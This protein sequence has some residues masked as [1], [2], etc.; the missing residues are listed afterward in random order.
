MRKWTPR[1]RIV[2][3][4]NVLIAALITRGSPPDQLYRA[5]IRGDFELITSTAQI[6]EMASVLQRPRLRKYINAR[7]AR[8]VVENIDTR[9]IILRE[10]PDVHLSPDPK[11]DPIIATAIAGDVDLLVTGDKRDL[12]SLNSV[13]GIPIVAPRLA[14]RRLRRRGRS[15]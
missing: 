3:D 8:V 9:A 11:D 12:L 5:W 6:A 13:E 10:I 1:V 4:T 2:L 14:L 7:E 15:T